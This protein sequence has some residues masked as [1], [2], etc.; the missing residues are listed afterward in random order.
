[1]G[2]LGGVKGG[3]LCL[4]LSSFMS[5]TEMGKGQC[6]N[7]FPLDWLVS[8]SAILLSFWVFTLPFSCTEP[9]YLVFLLC[10]L[11]LLEIIA[12]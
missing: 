10:S 8:G 2:G 1:M 9:Q 5:F 4:S 7:C 11:S 12:S 6:K 3:H